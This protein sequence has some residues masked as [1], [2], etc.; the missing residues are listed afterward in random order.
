MEL[1]SRVVG[2]LGSKVR[3]EGQ[4]G[5]KASERGRQEGL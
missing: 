4:K 1:V 3:T 2:M 5:G